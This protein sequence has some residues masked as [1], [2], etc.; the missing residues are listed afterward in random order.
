MRRDQGR[1][2]KNRSSALRD[3]T[4]QAR[5]SNRDLG[6]GREGLLS[7]LNSGLNCSRNMLTLDRLGRAEDVADMV[8]KAVRPYIIRSMNSLKNMLN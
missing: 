1:N 5:L 7:E 4:T 8:E 6:A 3:L 2:I